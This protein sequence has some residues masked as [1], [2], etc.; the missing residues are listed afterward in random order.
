MG[1]AGFEPA[2]KR[3]HVLFLYG[4]IQAIVYGLY[5]SGL[6]YLPPTVAVQNNQREKSRFTFTQCVKHVLQLV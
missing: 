6:R 3:L 2:A 1:P 4:Y 5:P